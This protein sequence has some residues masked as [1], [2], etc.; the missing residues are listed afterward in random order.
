MTKLPISEAFQLP[1]GVIYLDGNSLGPLPLAAAERIKQT[2]HSEWG[3]M[4]IRGWTEANWIDLPARVG[5]RIAG[6]IGAKPGSVVC[7]D[8]T[9]L[10]VHKAVSAALALVPERRQI[11]SDTGNFPTDLYV[12]QGL[13]NQIDRGHRLDLVE[14]EH[15]SNTISEETAVVMLTQVD[16]R[17]GRL[18]DMQ[19]ITK[20]AHASGAMVI[21][22]LAHSTGALP[23]DVSACNAEFAVGC[24]YKYLNGGP[25]APAFLYVRPDLTEK[26]EP[27]LSGWLGHA[28]PF[29]FDHDYRP[30]PGIDRMRVGTPPI[31]SM[32]AL[33]AALELWDSVNIADVRAASIALADR[34]IAEVETFGGDFGLVL[35]SPRDGAKRGSQVSFHAIDGYAIMQALIAEGVI[36]DFRAPD[37]MRFGFA[38]LYLTE[39]NIVDAADK[40]RIILEQRLW[41]KPAHR[42]RAAVT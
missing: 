3:Q 5:N 23:V 33:D 35:A 42:M 9:S 11:L 37:L 25:G 1:D 31:L 16:Y 27:A 40:L 21:W 32:A 8:S 34:F 4:L 15:V 17:T 29:D 2:T 18:H 26:I 7:C 13:I 19:A 20:K 30:A 36:G 12:A 22:D 38:P 28:M 24:G 10:N 6:L 39:Q 14:P 41:D